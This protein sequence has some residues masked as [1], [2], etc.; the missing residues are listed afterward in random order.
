MKKVELISKKRVKVA[1]NNAFSGAFNSCFLDHDKDLKE[2]IYTNLEK[3]Q[4][5]LKILYKSINNMEISTVAKEEE[6][7][8]LEGRRAG[9][10]ACLTVLNKSL[11]KEGKTRVPTVKQYLERTK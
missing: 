10:I 1:I 11:N 8:F 2:N 5:R 7:L 6:A 9:V 3:V 4:E